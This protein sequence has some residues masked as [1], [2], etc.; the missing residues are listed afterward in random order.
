MASPSKLA[1]RYLDALEASNRSP[2]QPRNTPSPQ[3]KSKHQDLE[4]LARQLEITPKNDTT[5]NLLRNK[6][7]TSSATISSFKSP[8]NRSSASKYDSPRKGP[9]QDPEQPEWATT[10]YRNILNSSPRRT[11]KRKSEKLSPL[12]FDTPKPTHSPYLSS[13][14]NSTSTDSPGYEYLCRIQAIK[15]WLEGVLGEEIS[16][17]PEQLIDYIRN[18]IHLAKLANTVLP[19]T[20]NVF[21]NDSKLQFRHTENINRFFQLLDYMNVPD[22]FRFELTDLYDAKNVPK[23][24]FCL[25][26]LSYMLH[27]SNPKFGKLIDLVDTLEFSDDDIRKANRALVGTGLPNFASADN[28]PMPQIQSPIACKTPM[29]S[30]KVKAG[31]FDTKYPLEKQN[32]FEDTINLQHPSNSKTG[33]TRLFQEELKSRS[34]DEINKN[35]A[36]DAYYSELKSFQPE[37]MK[38]Q[39]LCRGANFRYK[40]FVDRIILK[41][42]SEEITEFESICRGHIARLKTVHRNRKEVTVHK[43]QIISFQSISRSFLLQK[44]L[45]LDVSDSSSLVKLQSIIRAKSVQSRFN[46]VHTQLND[47]SNSIVGLQSQIRKNTVYPVCSVLI[48]NKD[49]LVPQIIG[50]QAYCRSHIYKMSTNKLELKQN[51]ISVIPLQ[52]LIRGNLSRNRLRIDLVRLRKCR[53]QLR[54]LQSIARGG[55]ARTK[56]CNEILVSLMFED[57]SL[58]DFYALIRGKLVRNRIANIKISLHGLEKTSVIPIQ[59]RFRGIFARFNKEIIL[60]DLYENLEHAIDFQSVARGFLLRK[61]IVDMNR[62][63]MINV[64]SVIKAQSYIKAAIH[65]SSYNSLLNLKN[66]PLSVIRQFAYLLTDND[67]DYQEIMELSDMK[68]RII[69]ISKHNETLETQIENLDIKLTLLDNNKITID[70]FV[71]SKKLSRQYKPTGSVSATR[72]N[73]SSKLKI[74]LFESIFYLLQ[75]KPVYFIRL[76]ESIDINSRSS[77]LY[78]DLQFYILLLYPIRSTDIKDHGREEY[79]YLKFI[80]KLMEMDIDI[81]CNAISELTKIQHCFWIEFFQ[82]FNNY[83]Y[84]R[85][86]LKSLVGKFVGH[87][88]EAEELDFELDPV[89]IYQSI[90]EREMAV[91]GFTDKSSGITA[92]AAIKQSDVSAKFVENLMSLREAATEFLNLLDSVVENLPLHVRLVCKHAYKLSQR[93]YPDRSHH[94]HLSVAGVIFIK[95]YIAA[96]LQVPENFGLLIKDPFNSALYSAKSKDNLKHLSRVMLQLF[97][98]KLFSDNFLKPL[99][100]YVTSS[101]EMTQGII[102]KLLKVDEIEVEMK[103][104]DYDDIVTHIRPKLSMNINTMISFEKLIARHVDIIAPSAD[105][106][107]Y[108]LITKAN[109]IV[110]SADDLLS[111]TEMGMIT[112]SLN[113]TTKEES[114]ADSKSE[115]L[116]TQVKRCIL[117][118]IRIQEGDGLLDLLVSPIKPAD[119]AKFRGIVNEEKEEANH[120]QSSMKRRPYYK[121]S[122]GDLGTISYHQLKK[123]AL[124]KLLELESKNMISRSD[125]YQTILNQ[126][127]IDIKSKYSQRNSRKMELS[128]IAQA[129]TTLSEKKKVL[130]RQ[131]NDYNKHVES[132]LFQIQL[133]PKEKKFFSIIPVFSKQY[134]YHRELRKKNRLPKFGSYKYTAKKLIEQ[135]VL[136]DFSGLINKAYSSSSKLDFMFSCHQVGKFTIEAATG[137]VAVS[138]ALSVLTLDNL[139]D[140]QYEGQP[141][142]DIF[143]GMVI[144]NSEELIGLIFRKFY[145]IKKE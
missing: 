93:Y 75:T 11:P 67:I 37:V 18:G 69:E 9:T 126:I 139:L 48:A 36:Y 5:T 74:E 107:L 77:R 85:H 131:L 47:Y 25:H 7:E 23:V 116:F 24:W 66:P 35:P 70:E 121:T 10:N 3:K 45:R 32:P 54:E 110:N 88:V 142:L 119:E 28:E 56:V 106:Q 79:F 111:L 63:Y 22:L 100:D 2:L 65:R 55:V 130:E 120:S 59:T 87:V 1:S 83:T 15:N 144:F 76:F 138:G 38:L 33:G 30:R 53:H 14:G 143:D 84:Q 97:S 44:K 141:K 68:D 42:F 127:A 136:V 128:M 94:Q 96:I 57:E 117:Y 81:N 31:N 123:M 104:N 125:S 114:V 62:H 118:V 112:I 4:I 133:K 50:F 52:A 73:K 51:G 101:M 137:S 103:I 17:S 61:H 34:T 16:Q 122:L 58:N 102:L 132:L 89:V 99:N 20:K 71:K 80:F 92:Q 27:K 43:N 40:M 115:V 105:D 135:K 145:E 8:S 86:Y 82:H 140:L 26:A 90:M 12:K 91:N 29:E 21:M 78:K 129:V 60:E 39:S 64:K 41:S 95:H 108:V 109:E 98:M 6:Y 134:F 113:P 72:V 13:P 46:R 49:W 124:A 19:N